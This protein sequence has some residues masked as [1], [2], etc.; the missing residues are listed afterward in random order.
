MFSS[1]IM[2]SFAVGKTDIPLCHHH[3]LNTKPLVR[4]RTQ[5]RCATT[6][7]G[8]FFCGKGY[9]C[10][11]DATET[12]LPCRPYTCSK[13][14]G[15]FGGEECIGGKC[16]ITCGNWG[17]FGKNGGA[18][19]RNHA[20]ELCKEHGILSKQCWHNCQLVLQTGLSLKEKKSK[21]SFLVL[22]E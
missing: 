19:G 3:K 21:Q 11:E 18:E 22:E 9:I 10:Y 6:F 12:S 17:I 1:M 7:H 20:R 4:P 14:S 13:N 5:C 2:V 15:C 8:E 16:E